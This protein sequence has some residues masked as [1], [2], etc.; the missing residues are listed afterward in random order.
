[1]L[2]AI[3]ENQAWTRYTIAAAAGAKGLSKPDDVSMEKVKIFNR[4]GQQHQRRSGKYY[5]EMTPEQVNKRM[6]AFA[7]R[8]EGQK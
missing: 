1:M 4:I 6:R 5:D 2:K 7:I 8:A 3:H